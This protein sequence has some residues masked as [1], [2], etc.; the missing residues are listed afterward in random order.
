MKSFLI[1]LGLG[2]AAGLLFA[3]ASG[4]ETRQ[5]LADKASEVADEVKEKGINKAA[6]VV[7]M[8]RGKAE[9]TGRAAARE[10]Y[11]RTAEKVVGPEIA[12]RSK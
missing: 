4:E 10:A 2:V 11:D 5:Q 1:G 12:Q 7:R 8:G 3:P 9:E 6:E